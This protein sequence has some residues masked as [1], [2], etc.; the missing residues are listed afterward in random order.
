MWLRQRL[1]ELGK[2]SR[3]PLSYFVSYRKAHVALAKL[4]KV[5]EITYSSGEASRRPLDGTKG[6]RCDLGGHR[7]H[8]KCPREQESIGIGGVGVG[9]HDAQAEV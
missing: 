3:G 8:M 4:A 5:L 2:D 1:E 6:A 9:V 7:G